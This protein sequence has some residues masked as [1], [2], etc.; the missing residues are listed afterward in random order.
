M[1]D[2]MNEIK[3]ETC[4]FCNNKTMTLRES[5]RDIPYFGKVFLFS[6]DCE[7]CNYHKSDLE[8]ESSG[9]AIKHVLEI[10][11][12]DD[13]KIRVVK[14]SQGKIILPRI[15]SIEPGEAANGYVTN[16]EGVLN[17]IKHQIEVLRENSDDKDDIKK[18]KNLLKKL[19]RV[20]WGQDTL[21]MTLEDPTGNSAIISDKVKS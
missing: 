16:V 9:K 2:E 18:A 15:G 11:C 20:L 13:L 14:S 12:E 6:M 21:K 10:T 17:R 4:P 5:D 3:G 1:A 8:L 7:S 19:Q